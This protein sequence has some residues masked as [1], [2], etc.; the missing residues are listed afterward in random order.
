[1]TDEDDDAVVTIKESNSF[2]RDGTTGL[3]LW[4][5]AI[6]LTDFVL[7][8]SK[9]FR[10][11]SVL[12]LGS[13]ASGFVGIT[14]GRHCLPRKMIMSDCHGSVIKTLM[15]NVRMNFEKFSSFED[16]RTTN[17]IDKIVTDKNIE[18]GILDLPWEDADR[19]KEDLKQIQP[20][21]VLAADVVYDDTI[22]AALIG[23]LKEIFQNFSGIDFYLSQ[24]IRNEDTFNKFCQ[25]L[26]ENGFSITN[27]NFLQK[28]LKHHLINEDAGKI[29]ILKV[30]R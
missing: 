16:D 7:Q 2:I 6:A 19:C 12:E 28:Y 18:I 13:G 3:V 26:K 14:L 9:N 27:Q 20:D 29:K 23:C 30:N 24:T 5:A 4:P 1:M 17:L 21:I 10:N 22:F 8:N 11:K 15:E 25:L